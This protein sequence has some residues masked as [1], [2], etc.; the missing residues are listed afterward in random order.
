MSAYLRQIVLVPLR[1]D[2]LPRADG[3][4]DATLAT[5]RH[6]Y[7]VRLIVVLAL[8]LTFPSLEEKRYALASDSLVA[9]VFAH[10]LPALSALGDAGL[11]SVLLGRPVP[12]RITNSTPLTLSQ[13]RRSK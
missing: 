7:P 1:A 10:A 2:H 12:V 9:D 11:A 6:G 5:M 8:L 4:G 13:T 3:D